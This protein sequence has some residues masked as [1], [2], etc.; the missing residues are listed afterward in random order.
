MCLDFVV[1]VCHP[2]HTLEEEDPCYK[3][4][5]IGIQKI[6]PKNVFKSKCKLKILGK[7]SG[8]QII[9]NCTVLYVYMYMRRESLISIPSQNPPEHVLSA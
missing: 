8:V 7:Y 5:C 1:A 6:I 4:Q 3:R 9:Y 2:V